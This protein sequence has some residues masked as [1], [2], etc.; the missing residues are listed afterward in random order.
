MQGMRAYGVSRNGKVVVGECY[1]DDMDP[2][3]L[4]VKWDQATNTTVFLPLPDGIAPNN[5]NSMSAWSVSEDGSVIVGIITVEELGVTAHPDNCWGTMPFVWTAATG[6][7]FLPLPFSDRHTMI[8]GEGSQTCVSPNGRYIAGHVPL[9]PNGT[10]APWSSRACV[11]ESD[12]AGDWIIHLVPT[13]TPPFAYGAGGINDDAHASICIQTDESSYES[14]KGGTWQVGDAAI[15]NVI[16]YFQPYGI[17]DAPTLERIGHTYFD[18]L[19]NPEGWSLQAVVARG[20]TLSYLDDHTGVLEPTDDDNDNHSYGYGITGDGLTACGLIEAAEGWNDDE[21]E[22]AVIWDTQTGAYTIL[23]MP[24]PYLPIEGV[25]W[26]LHTSA[27]AITRTGTRTIII[28]PPPRAIVARVLFRDEEDSIRATTIKGV[29][30]NADIVFA[31]AADTIAASVSLTTP[32]GVT[33]AFVDGV[34]TVSALVSL[35]PPLIIDV[36]FSDADDTIAASVEVVPV[37]VGA[38]VAFSDADDIIVSNVTLEPIIEPEAP[39]S[40]NLLGMGYGF[41]GAPFVHV[42][43]H[44]IDTRTLAYGFSG[45]PFLAW[46]R[47]EIVIEPYTTTGGDVVTTTTGDP[48]YPSS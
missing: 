21:Q 40:D 44:G 8:S 23:E 6:T 33:V 20:E 1:R 39:T 5:V 37:G 43:Y 34:D 19:G 14:E 25:M 10:T 3:G 26:N 35:V 30:V 15:D 16:T 31:D 41:G 22:Y 32:L 4:A 7:R 47:S 45:A 42:S 17:A 12:G 11:W 48:L 46:A 27:N 38:I 9:T 36:A 29:I 18:E 13:T 28:P 2:L 24:P